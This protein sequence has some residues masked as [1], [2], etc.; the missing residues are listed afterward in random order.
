[1]VGRV[2]LLGGT[3][4]PIHVGHLILA[5]VA[6]TEV[7]LDEVLFVP[8]GQPPHKLSEHHTSP[9]QRLCMLELA[10]ADNPRFRL[11]TAD[12]HRPGPHY[13]ADMVALLQHELGPATELFFLMGL[14]SLANIMTWHAPA[15][16]LEQCRLVVGR[17]PGYSVDIDHIE[18]HLPG[19]RE[20]LIFVDMPLIDIAGVD[21]RARAHA[22]RSLRYQVPE[23]VC[24]Y[25]AAEGLYQNE[26][27]AAREE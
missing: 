21:L 2:G 27:P 26:A 10:I 4:D 12:L 1:V 5:E 8:A 13:S 16:L 14:D 9:Q 23:A 6:R 19:L 11:S 3:F 22:G 24:R 25:I 7:P 17:R 18:R 15:R 20:R